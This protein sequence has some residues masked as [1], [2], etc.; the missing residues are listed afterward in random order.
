M[1]TITIGGGL[2]HDYYNGTFWGRWTVTNGVVSYGASS[3]GSGS[4]GSGSAGDPQ[5][6]FPTSAYGQTVP[7][8]W[9]TARIPG[10]YIWAPEEAV[11]IED[12]RAYI[13]AR[14]RFARPLVADSR[15]A[16]RRIWRDGKEIYNA[17]TGNR[18]SSIRAYDG[19]SSQGRDSKMVSVEGANNVSAHRGYLDI[20]FNHYN[21]GKVDEEFTGNPPAFEAEWVEEGGGGLEVDNFTAFFSDEIDSF[22]A[23][24]WDTDT[25]FGYSND[26]DLIRRFS[27]GGLNEIYAVPFLPMDG[28]TAFTS[29]SV[30]TPRYIP[31]IDRIVALAYVTTAPLYGVLIDPATGQVTAQ[32]ADTVTDFNVAASCY[33]RIG[34]ISLLIVSSFSTEV[35]SIFRVVGEDIDRTYNSGTAWN[36]YSVIHAIAPGEIREDAADIWI[37]ADDKLVKAVINSSGAF[38]SSTVHATFADDAV[39][40]VWYDNDVVVWTDNAQVIRVDGVTGATVYTQSVPYQVEPAG[41]LRELAPA[42]LN[43]FVDTF[44]YLIGVNHNFTDLDTGETEQI[45]T[46]LSPFRYVFDGVGERTITTVNAAVPY[47]TIF[48]SVGDGELRD[49][50]DFL[51]DLMVAGGFEA[52]DISVENVDDQIL[53]AVIDITGGVRDIARQICEP[54]SIAFFE[55]AGDIVFRRAL[56]DGAFAVEASIGATDIID[57]GGQAIRLTQR[58]PNEFVAKY[59]INYR[60]HEEIYQP[61]PQWGTIPSLP[62]AVAPTEIGIKADI[63]IISDGD[64][65]KT[66]ATKRVYRGAVEKHQFDMELRAGHLKIEPES[67]VQFT[68]SSRLVTARVL[69]QTIKPNYTNQIIATEFLSSVSVSI[70]GASGRP[71][72]PQPAGPTTSRYFHL[73]IPLLAGAHDLAGSGLLNYH[74]LAS[75]GQAFWS[76]ATLF[77]KD[78]DTYLAQATQ[79]T[80]GLVGI[81]LEV[82]PDVDIPYATEFERTLLV[83]FPSTVALPISLTYEEMLSGTDNYFAIGQPGRWEVVQVQTITSNGDGTAT[84]ETFRRCLDASEE[85]TGDHALGDYVVYLSGDNVQRLEYT[86]SALNDSFDFK[87]VGI[88]GSLATTPAVN[89]T[90]TGEAEKIPKPGN[91]QAVIDGSDIDLSWTRR[92]R[93]GSYWHDDGEDEYTAPLNESLEQYVLRIKSEP[94]GSVLRTF[95]VDDATTKT[96]LAADITTDFGSMPDQLTY[97]IRQVSGTGVICPTR[98]A[99]I[100][101]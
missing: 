41:Q 49:L 82:L 28:G 57:A 32:S 76:G 8:V 99:T 72:E 22:A 23:P 1:G 79:V 62:L 84:L 75:A 13:T 64:T 7:V 12:G 17:S 66:L 96:Y 71:V 5:Q 78:T 34:N 27:I 48:D 43:R 97:D 98:E 93:F 6:S 55:R 95:T 11:E 100:D 47:R 65:I 36:G 33:V 94:G 37:C 87:P 44:Y 40:S 21:M 2:P 80:D 25:F 74:V 19:H 20:V 58:N 45:T 61:R 30:R 77:R 54:Y 14:V 92:V 70:S 91:L 68:V 50:E 60:D 86:L 29:I 26:S 53:G 35:V 51:V 69:E 52:S 59:G 90:I 89:R 42:D 38:T 3:G 39:Y 15:W 4:G 31:E 46:G 88:G 18:P 16:L 73:D 24:D 63:P 10:G 9:G 85:Y 56:T 101:L 81:A 83:S 67:I